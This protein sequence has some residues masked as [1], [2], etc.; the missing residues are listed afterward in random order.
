MSNTLH[1]RRLNHGQSEIWLTEESQR[2]VVATNAVYNAVRQHCS[3]DV[4]EAFY[5]TTQVHLGNVAEV[6]VA[7]TM[8]HELGLSKI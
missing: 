2:R 5:S 1:A 3:K 6:F 7:G 4:F 8:A